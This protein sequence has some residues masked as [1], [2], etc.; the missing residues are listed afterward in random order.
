MAKNY[1]GKPSGVFLNNS[2]VHN[3]GPIGG[4]KAPSKAG[5]GKS[6]SGFSGYAPGMAK[7][8]SGPPK[9]KSK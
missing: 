5:G 8:S 1:N 2:N 4:Y 9:G 3:G 6:T 7:P